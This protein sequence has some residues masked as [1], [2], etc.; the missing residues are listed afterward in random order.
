M[1]ADHT[2]RGPGDLVARTARLRELGCD[3][4]ELSDLLAWRE[5]AEVSL[6]ALDHPSK[7]LGLRASFYDHKVAPA[8]TTLLELAE[9]LERDLKLSRKLH[10]QKCDQHM[11]AETR[12]ARLERQLAGMP[13]GTT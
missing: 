4:S 9:Q 6:K 2:C 12:A 13:G 10:A 3:V 11:E 1:N 8:M 7:Y 5:R